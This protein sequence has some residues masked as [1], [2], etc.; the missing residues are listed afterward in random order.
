MKQLLLYSAAILLSAELSAQCAPGTSITN[1][2]ANNVSAT[3]LNGGDMWWNLSGAAYE[4]PKGSGRHPLF[5]GALWLGGLDDSNNIH[6]ASQR[7]RQIGHDYFPGPLDSNGNTFVEQCDEYDRHWRITQTMI[8]SF[9]NDLYGQIPEVI[10]NWPG[11][12][13]ENLSYPPQ[14]YCA[15]FVDENNNGKYEP[16]LG[17]HPRIKGDMAVWWVMNDVGNVH[18]NSQGLPLGVEVQV[19]AYSYQTNDHVNNTTFYHYTVIN[20]S[21]QQY[22]DFY[23]GLFTDVDLGNSQ[24]DYIG[25]DS[26]RNLGFGYN[27]D[28]FDEDG[29]SSLGYGLNLPMIGIRMLQLPRT[30]DGEAMSMSSFGYANNGTGNTEDPHVASEYY[31]RLK[32]LWNDGEAM[33]EGGIGTSPLNPET[34]FVYPGNP[35]DSS[36]WSECSANI[37]PGDRRFIQSFGPMKLKAGHKVN[38][39]YAAIF[40]QDTAFQG[41]CSDAEIFGQITDEVQDFHNDETCG[42]TNIT[43]SGYVTLVSNGLDITVSGNGA[44][45]YSYS[46]TGPGGFTSTSAD[47]EGLTVKGVYSVTTTDYYGCTSS[48]SFEFDPIGVSELSVKQI[49]VSPNPSSS[50][51]F[52]LT[53]ETNIQSIEVFNSVGQRLVARFD[54]NSGVLDLSSF[55]SGIY[56]VRISDGIHEAET[57]TLIK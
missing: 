6:L 40:A 56:F 18:T 9:T 31:N 35:S 36:E 2:N 38:F 52:N 3:M 22:K 24:D 43:I 8:D 17:D 16:E 33:T 14:D 34:K 45:P 11:K 47:L 44:Q 1:L 37:T 5:S 53:S 4:V 7:Y 27:G 57:H 12:G 15:P 28:P 23:V 29:F 48:A 41:G 54:R 25:C 26:T 42:N 21:D 55:D 51:I 30:Q 13:N 39:T 20:K 32:G 10:L 19:M 49:T 50:G 46:W